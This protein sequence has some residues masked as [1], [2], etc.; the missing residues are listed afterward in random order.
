LTFRSIQIENGIPAY[1]TINPNTNTAYISYT[2][3]DFILVLD[4]DKGTIENKIKASRPREIFV[5][6]GTNKIYIASTWGTYEVD[7]LTNNFEL[8]KTPSQRS[9]ELKYYSVSSLI[10]HGID[11][12][13]NANVKYVANYENKSISVIDLNQPDIPIDTINLGRGKW[14]NTGHMDPSFILVNELSNILYV[15]THWIATG[16]GGAEGDSLIAIDIKT[17]KWRGTH[18][19]PRYGQ[20]GFAF[21]RISNALYIKKTS[22]KAILKLDPYLKKIST[23][24]LEKKSIWK[25]LTEGVYEYF[26]EVIMVNPSTNKVYAS[27]SKNNLLYEIDG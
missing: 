13:R 12:D 8:L 10:T 19:L 17:K 24:A 1:A 2:S 3:S 26:G 5:D 23:T 6:I 25:R 7:G 15:K 20:V 4:I 14:G 21:D 9:E 27:D 18:G 11:F 22:G 16:G